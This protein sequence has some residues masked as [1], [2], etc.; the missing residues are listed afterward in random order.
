MSPNLAEDTRVIA[1]DPTWHGFGVVVLEGPTNLID[2]GMKKSYSDNSRNAIV[3]KIKT[4]LDFYEPDVLVV[5]DC[6]HRLSRRGTSAR[7]II[8]A[9]LELAAQTAVKTR[10]VSIVSVRQAFSEDGRATKHEI[11]IALT[12]QFPELGVHLPAKRKA[13]MPED[14][15]MAIFDAAALALTAFGRSASND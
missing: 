9:I 14:P 10:R 2:W 3:R 13:W 11:A 4:I 1:I 6:A 5:E 15:R 8:R 12:S 7:E